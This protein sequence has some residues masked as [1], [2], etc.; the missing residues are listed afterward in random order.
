MRARTGVRGIVSLTLLSSSLVCFLAGSASAQDEEAKPAAGTEEE[1]ETPPPKPHRKA[2]EEAPAEE[3]APP[4]E[5]KP[6]PAPSGITLG[7]FSGWKLTMDGRINAFF[8]YGFGNH[9]A[10]SAPET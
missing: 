4:P 3:V 10:Q 5:V 1:T 7:N 6:A 2:A 9:N 8:V